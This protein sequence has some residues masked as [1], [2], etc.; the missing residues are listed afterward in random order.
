MRHGRYLALVM[1]LAAVLPAAGAAT[2][3]SLPLT[4]RLLQANEIPGY[5]PKLPS[6]GL[7]GLT[8]YLKATDTAS[9]RAMYTAAGFVQAAY[10]K[11][12]APVA[13]A[14]YPAGPQDDSSVVQLGSAAQAADVR[15]KIIRVVSVPPAG[16]KFVHFGIAGIPGAWAAVIS[17]GGISLYG[18]IF[19]AG[20]YVYGVDAP[21]IGGKLSRAQ[22]QAAMVAY[23]QRVK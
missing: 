7:L 14:T 18:A 13:L 15:S 4:E 11:L 22:F 17:M 3:S 9:R 16:F 20:P 10:E 5:V 12:K 2:S 8:A 23:Y 19:A 1:L 6:P 21:T